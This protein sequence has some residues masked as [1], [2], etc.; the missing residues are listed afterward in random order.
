MQL[1]VRPAAAADIDDAFLWYEDQRPGLGQEFLAAAQAV[2]DAIAKH[3]L[4]YPVI[5]RN[6]QFTSGRGGCRG[7]RMHAWPPQSEAMAGAHV[8][9]NNAA[10]YHA[11]RSALDAPMHSAPRR[12]T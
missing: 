11:F 4:R 1:V 12:G 3:P 6:T 9:A 8:M 10:E 2:I 7:G 5:R